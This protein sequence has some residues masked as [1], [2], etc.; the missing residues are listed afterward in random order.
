MQD[1]IGEREVVPLVDVIVEPDVG[2]ERLILC[3]DSR[4][5]LVLDL[6]E[7][8]RPSS[9]I[10]IASNDRDDRFAHEPNPIDGNDRTIRHDW[11]VPGC[12][13]TIREIVAREEGLH[14]RQGSRPSQIDPDDACVRVWA[15]KEPSMEHAVDVQIADERQLARDSLGSLAHRDR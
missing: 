12:Q 3:D 9:D 11:A 1:Q 13:L 4:Q 2:V 15:A 14:A 8:E 6:D 5:L 10:W 7:V